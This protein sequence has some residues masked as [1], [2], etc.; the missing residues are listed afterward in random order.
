MLGKYRWMQANSSNFIGRAPVLRS[1]T[2]GHYEPPDS[3]QNVPKITNHILTG[4]LFFMTER[5]LSRGPLV[6]Q[7]DPVIHHARRGF[8]PRVAVT[9]KRPATTRGATLRILRI[10]VI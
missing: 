7:R 8:G 5:H 9:A 2:G 10:S 3:R 4:T 1:E 6:D